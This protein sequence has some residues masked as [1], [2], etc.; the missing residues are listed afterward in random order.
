MKTFPIH[1]LLISLLLASG[2]QTAD[3]ARSGRPDELTRASQEWDRHFNAG[4][5]AALT[6]LYAENAVSMP[7]SLPT[8]QGRA[9]LQRDFEGF[10]AINE[11]R[12]ETTVDEI[13]VEGGLAIERA[14]YRLTYRPRGGGAEV[15]ETGR[16]VEC[17]RRIGDQ[18]LIVTEIWNTDAPS[19]K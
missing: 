13:I 10:F 18:W 4:D 1:A 3:H 9:A 16:H 8:L 14:H 5:A 19:P 2:C 12:H 11:A 6:A 15:V 7:P 17:R